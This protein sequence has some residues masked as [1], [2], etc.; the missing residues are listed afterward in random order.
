MNTTENL[1][2]QIE[3][4][5]SALQRD[6]KRKQMPKKHAPKL[7]KSLLITLSGCAF[8]VHKQTDNQLV[9]I[10]NEKVNFEKGVNA[11]RVISYIEGT[12]DEVTISDWNW[13]PVRWKK[14][15]LFLKPIAPTLM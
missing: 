12:Y 3:E 1:I 15:K 6:M 4:Q 13:R 9:L 11:V 10:A 14:D 2:K 7:E 5:T 8:N